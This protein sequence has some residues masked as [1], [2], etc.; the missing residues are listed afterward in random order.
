MFERMLAAVDDS[1]RSALV[2]QVARALALRS[3]A[4][5]M[6]LRVRPATDRDQ[7]NANDLELAEETRALR[8]AGIAAHYLIHTGAPE[9]QIIETARRQRATLII[10]G[11][12]GASAWP[13]LSQRMS[14]RLA[15]HAPTPVLVIPAAD[16]EATAAQASQN[17][18]AVFGAVD[19]PIVAPLDGSDLAE[20]ALPYAV[21]LARLLDRPLMLL[22]V[23]S[24]LYSQAQLAQ[25]WAYIEGARRRVRERYSRDLHVETHVVSGAP[26]EETLWVIEG[27]RAGA[28]VVM[29]Y[30]RQVGSP[31]RASPISR[32]L[33]SK[34]PIPT[35]VVPVAALSTPADAEDAEDA[36]GV[37][38]VEETEET[39]RAT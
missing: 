35:L 2:T 3:G 15:I 27:R 19:A 4:T 13:L 29:Q 33:L 37:G 7:V 6:L 5:L 39:E 36:E 10:V 17:G 22:R 21:E 31:R 18:E 38:D 14:Q 8:E 12:R 1:A 23:A 20:Q 9:Q 11:A 25:A 28:L 32:E 34:L 26:V 30:G 24:P 16:A